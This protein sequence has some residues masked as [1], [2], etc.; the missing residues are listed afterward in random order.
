MLFQNRSE[1]IVYFSHVENFECL[2]FGF[3]HFRV[4]ITQSTKSSSNPIKAIPFSFSETEQKR[5]SHTKSPL[6]LGETFIGST[7][8][9]EGA[10][11]GFDLG[12]SGLFKLDRLNGFLEWDASISFSL[13]RFEPSD[14]SSVIPDGAVEE[15]NSYTC[16]GK[17][18]FVLRELHSGV[19]M[20]L[21]VIFSPNRSIVLHVK[22][23]SR[24]LC[25]FISVS[26]S[27]DFMPAK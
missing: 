3:Y 15:L 21:S 25:R 7:F 23:H 27:N 18:A 17:R 1:A 8:L 19:G 20:P 24:V 2:H 11:K 10:Y 16:I 26:E 5:P 9:I 14:K 22:L 13:W 12:E 6:I 4:E